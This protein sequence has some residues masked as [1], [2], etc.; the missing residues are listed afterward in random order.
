VNAELDGIPLDRKD[1]PGLEQFR[2]ILRARLDL[3]EALQRGNPVAGSVTEYLAALESVGALINAQ[4]E[5]LLKT[6]SANP[7][8]TGIPPLRE[9]LDM[10]IGLHYE[11]LEAA[12]SDD[13][14]SRLMSLPVTDNATLEEDISLLKRA[15]SLV[16]E[17]D[18]RWA[19]VASNLGSAYQRR[20][21]G[22][23]IENWETALSLIQRACDAIDRSADP[24]TWAVYQMNYGFLLGERPGGSSVDDFSRGIDHIRAALEERSP[25]S[26]V[27][28]W[29]YSL[30][31][32][33]FL[34]QRRKAVGDDAIARDCYERALARLRPDDDLQLW[35]TLQNNL[36]DLIIS[37]ESPDLDAAEAAIRSAQAEI[38]STA[39]PLMAGRLI[40]ELARIE[41]RRAGPLAPEAQ[42]LRQDALNL[43]GPILAPNLHLRI[44]NELLDAY[45]QLNDWHAAAAIC[46]SMLTAF[47]NLYDVQASPAA[48]RTVLASNPRLARWAAYVFARAGR[49]EEAVEAIEHGRARQLSVAVSRDTA[50]LV[51]L[52]GIDQHLADRY[53]A[54]LAGYRAALGE[55]D[56]ALP[57][58]GAGNRISAAEHDMQQTLSAIRDIP[59][60]ERFLKPMTVADISSAGGEYPVIYLVSAPQ[61]SYVLT[62]QSSTAGEPTVTS[63]AVPEVTSGDIAHLVLLGEDGSPGIISAQSARLSAGLM[64][65]ALRRL[66]EIEPL[67]RPVADTL[68]SAPH[69]AV[70]VIPTGLLGLVPLPAVSVAGQVLDDI[71]EIHL[72]PSAAVY[73]ACRVRASQDQPVHL[74]GI[75]NPDGTLLASEAELAAIRG[76]FELGSLTS[77]AVGPDA[78]RTWVLEN[79]SV[80]TH[81]HL[82]CHGESTLSSTA[83]GELRL[84]GDDVLTID[85]LL[86]G[87]LIGCRLAVASACQSGHYVTAEVPDEFTGLPAGFLQAGAACAIV[88]LWKVRDDITSIFMTRFYEL[89]ETDRTG[90]Q[91]MPARALREA[92]AWLRGLDNQQAEVF[93]QTHPQLFQVTSPSMTAYSSSEN[94]APFVAWGC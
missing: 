76:L 14:G 48:R 87:R 15:L 56:R 93:K 36:A 58:T 89:L 77:C 74:V 71:G 31:N 41:E 17:G 27:V 11:D 72:A 6:V 33:G 21:S 20:I 38:D 90:S 73:A 54:A 4:L 66:S 79:L 81:L 78:T 18:P 40:W 46:V 45:T 52:D 10:A 47:D 37:G 5:H 61:G 34:Y 51:R 70:V 43:L 86:D 53:R 68:A 29:S 1:D 84:A 85:D 62:V 26:N 80:A 69:H 59:G 9:A 25:E 3:V 83:G 30:I 39:D 49:P 65:A 60:F 28:D 82:A 42:S 64:Q 35:T 55:T 57:G 2:T 16:P 75:A 94:W 8:A 24:R 7:E 32:L 12:L 22:D 63:V 50:D 44:G 91:Q 13:L 19:R 67:L 23:A 92:R 88:S